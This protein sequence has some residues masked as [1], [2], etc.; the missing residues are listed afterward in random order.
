M[1]RSVDDTLKPGTLDAKGVRDGVKLGGFSEGLSLGQPLFPEAVLK[2]QKLKKALSAE[3]QKL[4]DEIAE[5]R[6]LTE[7]LHEPDTKPEPTTEDF[8]KLM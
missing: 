7:K 5:L 4:K 1:R 3:M 8:N 2:K 6:N